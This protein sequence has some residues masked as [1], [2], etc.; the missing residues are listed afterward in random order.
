MKVLTAAYL[1]GFAGS[2]LASPIYDG[3]GHLRFKE[4]SGVTSDSIHNIHIDYVNEEY[5]GEL[6][7]V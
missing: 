3:Q 6:H 5:S 1:V 2:A 7:M 4:V